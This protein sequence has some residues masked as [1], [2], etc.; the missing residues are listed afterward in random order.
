MKPVRDMLAI[1]RYAKYLPLLL[2]IGFGA[3][4]IVASLLLIEVKLPVATALFIIGMTLIWHKPVLAWL[5]K[6]KKREQEQIDKEI[7]SINT[8][9]D[10]PLFQKK[11]INAATTF[12]EDRY[13]ELDTFADRRTLVQ[14]GN[15]VVSLPPKKT[16]RVGDFIDRL[17]PQKTVFGLGLVAAL[18]FLT[19]YL[20]SR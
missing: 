2:I 7:N 17:P 4:L 14:L 15:G 11:F 5:K 18:F 1:I 19:L 8:L 16:S 9:L 12:E 10:D 6:D 20:N 3:T 13:G